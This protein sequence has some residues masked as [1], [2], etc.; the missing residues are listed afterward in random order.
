MR[1]L[2]ISHSF[3]TSDAAWIT[4]FIRSSVE[5]IGATPTTEAHVL[6]PRREGLEV[7][8]A[9]L[10]TFR[11]S[12]S[13]RISHK[14]LKDDTRNVSFFQ[15]I[16]FLW[17]GVRAAV[18]VVRRER[19]EVIHAHWAIPSGLIAFIASRMTG[20]PFVVTVHGRDVLSAPAYG[21]DIPNR[22]LF[23]RVIAMVLTKSSA[24]I[25]ASPTTEQAALRIAPRIRLARI[26][27][28]VDDSIIG[29]DVTTE[30]RSSL[31][32]VG[33]LAPVKGLS[34][35]LE[36]LGSSE[37]LKQHELV[38]AGDGPLRADL[39]KMAARLG[40]N[41]RFLGYVSRA[42]LRKVLRRARVLILPS[43]VEAFGVVVLE[44]LGAGLCVAGSDVGI[45]AQLKSDPICGAKVFA[46]AP[47][48][49][50]GLGRAIERAIEASS[51]DTGREVENEISR[52]FNWRAVADAHVS[53]YRSL[54]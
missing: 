52:R 15:Q 33:D 38:V 27:V 11:I 44:A 22:P 32:Y 43:V 23:R 53:L 28:A 2:F 31:V 46:A 25:A 54:Q 42:D 40:L 3:P 26:P 12:R 4:P 50:N 47:L 8:H 41:A 30:Q 51:L 14:G 19:I 45:V 13:D 48:D 39:E 21:Y 18:A 24:V 17:A 34:T 35:L 20:V 49:V 1:V 37:R 10:H 36:A 16:N 9:R 6:L 5:A 7:T 29:S